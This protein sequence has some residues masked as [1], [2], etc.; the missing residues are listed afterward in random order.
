MLKKLSL[1]I[2]SISMIFIILPTETLASNY[3]DTPFS[4]TLT[5]NTPHQTT[6]SRAKQ[7][8]T[9]T[10]VRLDNVPA[11]STV[12]LSVEGYRPTGNGSTK[13]WMN[14]TIGGTQVARPGR[15]SVR[16]LVYENGGRNARL[17]FQR[18]SV[19]GTVNGLWSPDSIG[20]YPRLN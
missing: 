19:S 18:H 15:W 4:F 10:Y 12:L 3:S 2:L 1:F 8:S 11:G 13:V 9:S 14:E 5:I 7:N 16:Q 17:K 6:T 20:T